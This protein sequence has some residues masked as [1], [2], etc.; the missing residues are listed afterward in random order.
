MRKRI[1]WIMVVMLIVG[2]GTLVSKW[3]SEKPGEPL[4][5]E[6][7]STE[8]SEDR[9]PVAAVD[10]TPERSQ[11]G[12]KKKP[13]RFE[14]EQ[15]RKELIEKIRLA[16]EARE[17]REQQAETGKSEDPSEDEE[18]EKRAKFKE[19]VKDAVRLIIDDVKECYD[20]A[21][22][23][24]PELGGNLAVLFTYEGEPGLGGVVQS[25]EITE[26]SDDVLKNNP[27]FVKC[28][29]DNIHM[30]DLPEPEAG[31]VT[32]VTYPFT[33]TPGDEVDSD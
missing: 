15:Q 28:I 25:A 3:M 31:G 33:F 17:V 18:E 16:R 14:N 19:A 8:I 30:L 11:S 32:T 22:E 12:A 2:V 23:N 5:G 1:V 13:R 24:N 7:A 4:S 29:I 21:L 6:A 26:G 10:P 20:G 9:E 27:A